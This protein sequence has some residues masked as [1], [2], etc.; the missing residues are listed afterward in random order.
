MSKQKRAPKQYVVQDVYFQEAKK[1]GYRARSA[2]KLIEIQEQYH[3]IKPGMQICDIGCFPGSFIQ[4]I[5]RIVGPE[6]LIVGI[7][8]QKT[9]SLGRPNVHLLQQSILEY[10]AVRNFCEGLGVKE[11]DV[12][13]SD[14]APNTTGI[15]GVDQYRSI[16]LNFAILDF[17][18]TFLKTGG[19]LLLKVLIGEDI[20]DLITP[21]KQQY[22][23]LRR[24]KPKA[25]RERSFE[26]YFLCEGKKEVVPVIEIPAPLESSDV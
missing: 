6:D 16:E 23:T 17:A 19:D 8:I 15:T 22:T 5:A 1:Q 24:M 14:I 13:T 3:F 26:E 9:K 25:C 18:K 21:I 2:F 4:V 20:Q 11:F 7:D 10:D 12:I